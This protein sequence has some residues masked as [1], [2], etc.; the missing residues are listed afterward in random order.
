VPP[1]ALTD[2]LVLVFGAIAIALAGLFVWGVAIAWRGSRASAAATR[3]AAATAAIGAAGWMAATDLVARA[4]ILRQ[5][6]RTPPPLALLVLAIVALATAIALGPAGKRLA[7]LPLWL[8]VAVQGFR[9]PLELAMHEAFERGFMPEQMSYS[10]RN[11]DILTGISAIVVGALVAA[12]RAGGRLVLIW[13]VVGLALLINVVTVAI[14]SLPLFSYFGAEHLNTFVTYPPFVWLPAV[15]VLAA[16]MG[17]LIIFRA[18]SANGH[19][20]S[21]ISGFRR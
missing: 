21:A 16:L 7:Q 9:F 19:Q 12:G 4:G 6:D 11:F 13:N 14:L 1:S 5:W 17:H 8:L 2:P 3:R 15:M 20:P 18:L 10:G